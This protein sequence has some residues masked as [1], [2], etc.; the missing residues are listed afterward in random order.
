MS[1]EQGGISIAGWE[2][3]VSSRSLR[4]CNRRSKDDNMLGSPDSPA[5]KT[6]GSHMWTVPISRKGHVPYPKAVCWRRDGLL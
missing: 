1:L 3:L 2:C 6:T 5:H 4:L